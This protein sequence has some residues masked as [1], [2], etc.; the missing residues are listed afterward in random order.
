M[1]Y[2]GIDPGKAGGIA[3]IDDEFTMAWK[4]PSTERDIYE[5]IR[6][7]SQAGAFAYIEEVHAAPGNGVSSMFTFG[8][9]YGGLRMALIAAGIS[10]A[11][12]TPQRWEKYFR[13]KKQPSYTARKN[14]LKARAQELFVDIKM[15]LSICDALLIAKFGQETHPR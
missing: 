10:F 11:T 8:M 6:T 4:M 5:L 13:I 7:L 12:V 1:R 15:T 14:A 2:L 3:V 9:G